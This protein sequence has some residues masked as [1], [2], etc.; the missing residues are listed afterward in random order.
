MVKPL[1]EWT[2]AEV[3]SVCERAG[4]DCTCC[5]FCMDDGDCVVSDP[6]DIWVLPGSADPRAYTAG[7]LSREELDLC[8]RFGAKYVTRNICSDGKWAGLWKV[9]PHFNRDTGNFYNKDPRNCITM[10]FS[11]HF[12]SLEPGDIVRVPDE[13]SDD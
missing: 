2:L 8:R 13:V 3:R 1:S 4:K 12:P 5:P 6:P 7:S 9:E 11:A 10:L